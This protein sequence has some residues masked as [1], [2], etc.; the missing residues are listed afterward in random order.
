MSRKSICCCSDKVT[1]HVAGISLPKEAEPERDAHAVSKR[2]RIVLEGVLL[3]DAASD[4]LS[5]HTAQHNGACELEDDG[6]DH[7]LAETAQGPRMMS[8]KQCS[9]KTH[10]REC[11]Q[12]ALAAEAVALGVSSLR[13]GIHE[14]A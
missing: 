13:K 8:K 14:C 4:G 11:P 2:G 1:H 5:G 6:E 9:N 10:R 3:G 12:K 7:G